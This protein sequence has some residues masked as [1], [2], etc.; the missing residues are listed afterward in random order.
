[1]LPGLIIA[2]PAS[3]SGKTTVVCALTAA[4][5][6]RGVDVRTFKAGPDYLDPTHHQAITGQ[7]SRNL[8]GWMLGRDGVAMSLSRGSQGGALALIEGVMGLFDGRRP[9]GLEG[10]TAELAGWLG[11]RV[12]L[13][14]DAAA[15]ARSAA[16]I[17][18]GFA[19]HVSG[20]HIAGVIFNRVGSP[21]HA[22]LLKTAMQHTRGPDGLP[23]PC[24][25][26]LQRR[27]EFSI[28]HRHLG[29][30]TGASAGLAEKR[31]A[32]AAWVE[33][34]IDLD[35]LLALAAHSRLSLPEIPAV[36]PSTVRIGIAKDAAFHFYYDD[37][38][39]LLREAG[40]ELVPF[41]PLHDRALPDGL[42]GLIIGGGYPEVYA[43]QLM[44]NASMRVAIADF[45]AAGRPIYAECGGL[46]YLGRSLENADGDAFAMCG[47]LDLATAMDRALRTLGYREVT[48]TASSLLGPAGVQFRGHEF[49]YSH[50]SETPD[51]PRIYAW[52]GRRGAGQEGFHEGS[53]MASYIHAHWGSNPE[54]AASFVASCQ[55]VVQ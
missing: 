39:D 26:A 10:S 50:L 31:E 24:L 2:A 6:R 12:I 36:P 22:E 9:E 23:I 17:A 46:M 11:A 43:A 48:T 42:D 44:A 45:A 8:D 32:L 14:I 30:V 21:G 20:I 4:L 41:S 19:N 38:L 37:N 33:E 5:Q 7:A 47:V 34:S 52:T 40:A 27:P 18:E 54:I 28:P 51:A 49:H 13:V 15:M 25:G 3:G 29:L 55:G 35:A 16:A 53:V 1:M